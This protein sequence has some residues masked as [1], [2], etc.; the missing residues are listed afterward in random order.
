LRMQVRVEG[1]VRVGAG[2]DGA[3]VVVVLRKR[4][5]MVSG[6]LLF[7]V[8]SDGLLLF[9]SE[10]GDALACPC[11]IQGLACGNHKCLLLSVCSSSNGLSHG[12][13]IV[14]LLGGSGDS[15]GLLPVDS[16]EFGVAARYSRQDGGG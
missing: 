13:G 12:R 9:P 16:G 10:G 4:D 3:I 11:L 5:P 2:I 6:E 14:L 8:T 15:S 1:D 7:Q